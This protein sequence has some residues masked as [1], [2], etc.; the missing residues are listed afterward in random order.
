MSSSFDGSSPLTR[1]KLRIYLFGE[2]ARRL[3]P[4]HAGKTRGAH[5]LS[6]PCPA[7]PRSRGENQMLAFSTSLAVGSSPLTRG[8]PG[9][10]PDRWRRRRLIPAH[11]GKTTTRD[12]DHDAT[13]A[14]PRSRGE[15]SWLSPRTRWY[16][17]SSPL[18]RGK[19]DLRD[20]L[21]PEDRLI[22]AHAGKTATLR[23]RLYRRGAHPRSRGENGDLARHEC[24]HSG[25]SP[26]TRGKPWVPGIV[27][28]T[29]RLIPAHAG[30]TAPRVMLVSRARAH[31]RSRG[32]NSS[33]AHPARGSGGS[34]PLTRGKR[35]RSGPSNQH[36]GLIP[37]HAGKTYFLSRRSV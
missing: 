26:L 2:V 36:L 4:A 8:K 20:R 27:W 18:T 1:G 19:H 33:A 17:G 30:K 35:A 16:Q 9:L 6:M 24:L 34:S 29:N 31:P 21:T 23:F 12:A 11:A 25:S 7:H 13:R 32:E 37:A 22:P 14:H 15:N 5:R 10:L 28:E 3:I